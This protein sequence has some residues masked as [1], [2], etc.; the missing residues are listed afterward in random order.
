LIREIDAADVIVL[1]GELEEYSLDYFAKS[2]EL[3]KNVEEFEKA[4]PSPYSLLKDIE[5]RT[6]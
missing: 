6:K 3:R 1:L 4:Y 5:R 2:E